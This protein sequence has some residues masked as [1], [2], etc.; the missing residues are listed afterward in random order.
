M[1]ACD[2]SCIASSLWTRLFGLFSS[3]PTIRAVGLALALASCQDHDPRCSPAART[4]ANGASC[5][6]SWLPHRV[7]S[8]QNDAL[9]EVSGIAASRAHP[10]VYY[11]HNDSD[12]T[13]R[14][15][16]VD[17]EGRTLGEYS[18]PSA[19]AIDWED[20]A[21]GPSSA[22]DVLFLGDIGDNGA[23][24]GSAAPRGE[25]QIFRVREP[26]VR[27]DASPS[28][29]MVS[30]ERLRAVYPDRP[31]DAETLMV[32]PTTSELFIITKETDGHSGV[33][34]MSAR[35]AADSQTTL[36]RVAELAVGEC[37]LPGSPLITG[38]DISRGGTQIALLSY[39]SLFLW[40]RRSGQSLARSLEELPI[41]SAP[42]EGTTAE[43]IT[44]A[45]DDRALVISAE[46]ARAPLYRA[47]DDCP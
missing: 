17:L 8:I 1:A 22:G 4:G 2:K 15:F 46:G 38:G 25:V 43:A 30:W 11:V 5:P 28:Q 40:Q 45:E 26:E 21:L 34:R 27:L 20:I 47:V 18:L 24:D 29:Q 39:S 33:Y 32:D 19:N 31:H 3:R 41:A 37:Q 23:R 36:E 7:G 35:A 14:F 44:F 42:V 9:F 16:A 13:A 6:S 12:D 10:G